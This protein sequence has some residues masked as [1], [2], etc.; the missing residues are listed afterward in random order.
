VALLR[1]VEMPRESR[2][3]QLIQARGVTILAPVQSRLEQ[4]PL[5]LRQGLQLA[6]P[7]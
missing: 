5:R 2:L 4:A 6:L 1:M 3:A 7:P